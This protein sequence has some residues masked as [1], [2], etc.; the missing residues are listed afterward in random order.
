MAYKSNVVARPKEVVE[1]TFLEGLK[2]PFK[3]G[4]HGSLDYRIQPGTASWNLYESQGVTPKDAPHVACFA[5]ALGEYFDNEDFAKLKIFDGE[6]PDWVFTPDLLVAG[7]AFPSEPLPVVEG[8]HERFLARLEKFKRRHRLFGSVRPGVVHYEL[9]FMKANF[10]GFDHANGIL[11]HV[12]DKPVPHK[13]QN[14]WLWQLTS[15]AYKAT[16]LRLSGFEVN[17]VVFGDCTHFR[18]VSGDR[19]IGLLKLGSGITHLLYLSY[20]EFV[21]N[22]EMPPLIG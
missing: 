15:I 2:D 11:V 4:T 18:D 13:D 7:W 21:T 17:R 14:Y 20:E 10:H 16:I 12:A 1:E 6:L 5:D 3:R 19:L 9:P 8:E 22:Q